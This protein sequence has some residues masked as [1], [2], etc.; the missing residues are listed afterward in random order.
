MKICASDM[1]LKNLQNSFRAIYK[2]FY[3]VIRIAKIIELIE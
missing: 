2:Q 1:F 3:L